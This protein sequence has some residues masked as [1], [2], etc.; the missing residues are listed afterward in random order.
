MRKIEASFLSTSLRLKDAFDL[1]EIAIV[2]R[3]A[4]C[5]L[6]SIL[7]HCHKVFFLQQQGSKPSKYVNVVYLK[8]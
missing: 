2:V 5:N 1:I 7:L 4:F 3:N 8:T 6:K